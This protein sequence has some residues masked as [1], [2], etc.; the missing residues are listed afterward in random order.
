[1][2]LLALTSGPLIAGPSGAPS[3]PTP[4]TATMK[5]LLIAA[6]LVNF[7]DDRGGIDC[8][9]GDIVDVPKDT[10]FFLAQNERAL[11]VDKKDDPSKEGRYTADEKM[12]KAAQDLA[13]A[14][15]KA[16]EK[17]ADKPAT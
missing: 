11:Y 9:Q 3:N 1:M 10:A 13:K 6:C 5:I 15:A 14:R 7:G 2:P 4:D 16:A 17:P 8:A 12:V